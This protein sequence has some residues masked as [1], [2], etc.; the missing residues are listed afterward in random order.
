M[1]ITNGKGKKD[2]VFYEFLGRSRKMR[3]FLGF[4]DKGRWVVSVWILE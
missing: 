3:F 4:R 1:F 2:R